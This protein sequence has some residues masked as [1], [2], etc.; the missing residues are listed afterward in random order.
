[1][2]SHCIA[3]LQCQVISSL[4]HLLMKYE[5]KSNQLHGIFSAE[6]LHTFSSDLFDVY[7]NLF[8]LSLNIDEDDEEEKQ[9]LYILGLGFTQFSGMLSYPNYNGI[10]KAL[11]YPDVHMLA[12]LCELT[13]MDLRILVL[14]RNPFT[15]LMSTKRRSIGGRIE[16]K[17]LQ[18]NA[19]VIYAQ[20]RQIDPRF[21]YCL[22][23]ETL[24]RLSIEDSQR[25]GSFIHPILLVNNTITSML[26]MINYTKSSSHTVANMTINDL[27]NRRYHTWMLQ[28]NLQL[29]DDLCVIN[30]H[31]D[32]FMQVESF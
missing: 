31:P 13:C 16:P 2:F 6:D 30:N 24:G 14:R 11:D 9:V 27:L 21:Y 28:S 17:I 5:Q 32:Y 26:A 7:N 3:S 22:Q 19:A 18:T 8:E 20:L 25:L 23:F 1:M 12:V 10:H 29:I 4:T 15:I